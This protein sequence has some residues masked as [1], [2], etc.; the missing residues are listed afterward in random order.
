MTWEADH[1]YFEGRQGK[2]IR[3]ERYYGQLTLGWNALAE[4]ELL[5]ILQAFDPSAPARIVPS[6]VQPTLD[7]VPRGAAPEYM[8]ECTSKVPVA[9]AGD[10]PG[11]RH[12]L[13]LSFRTLSWLPER[14]EPGATQRSALEWLIAQERII[15]RSTGETPVTLDDP[16]K[17]DYRLSVTESSETVAGTVDVP[18][19][20]KLTELTPLRITDPLPPLPSGYE[21]I[22][23]GRL[24]DG[25][26]LDFSS[27]GYA[28]PLEVTSPLPVQE[29][30]DGRVEGSVLIDSADV[31]A[32]ESRELASPIVVDSYTTSENETKEKNVEPLFLPYGFEGTINGHAENLPT[33]SNGDV[34]TTRWVV[35]V[36][37]R[38]AYRGSQAYTDSYEYTSLNADGSFSITVSPDDYSSYPDKVGNGHPVIRLHDQ[39]LSGNPPR[40]DVPYDLFRTGETEDRNLSQYRIEGYNVTDTD[41]NSPSMYGP[42]FSNG[43]FLAWGHN[44]D[45]GRRQYQLVDRDTGDDVGGRWTNQNN[46]KE[47][48][49]FEVRL[50][51][52]S[53]QEY[54]QPDYTRPLYTD[55]TWATYLDGAV[56]NKGEW[57]VRLHRKSDGA[58]VVD[59]YKGDI[60]RYEELEVVGEL[61][62]GLKYQKPVQYLSKDESFSFDSVDTDRGPFVVKVRRQSDLELLGQGS[63]RGAVPR[64]FNY[65]P[66]DAPYGKRQEHRSFC[67]DASL[68][69]LVAT[70][71][72][73]PEQAKRLARGLL[74]MQN[75]GEYTYDEDDLPS[76]DSNSVGCFAWFTDHF[77]PKNWWDYYGQPVFRTA[78]D[79]WACYALAKYLS[80]FPDS[81]IAEEARDACYLVLDHWENFQ[82]PTGPP[83]YGGVKFGYNHYDGPPD[84]GYTEDYKPWLGW[85]AMNEVWWGCN[86]A[87]DVFADSRWKSLRDQIK[88]SLLQGFWVD[89]P[90]DTDDVPDGG[91]EV[92]GFALGV[93]EDTSSFPDEWGAQNRDRALD[94]WTWGGIW[95]EAVGEIERLRTM[96]KS[97]YHWAVVDESTRARGKRVSGYRPHS[98]WGG[99]EGALATL[100]YEGS[101]GAAL[102]FK[103]IGEEENYTRQLEELFKGQLETG[104]FLYAED[105]DEEYQIGDQPSAASTT[106]AVLATQLRHFL[107]SSGEVETPSAVVSPPP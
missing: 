63:G 64:S 35:R 20:F 83:F 25:T 47:L 98:P 21:G 8:C 76:G 62:V 107:W 3:Q 52:Y 39:S 22:V 103:R 11:G 84:Y 69:L 57:W 33:D 88:K 15:D 13:T 37:Y 67:Y 99:Y 79:G 81:E 68:A 102:Y 77:R 91:H 101:F 90:D 60:F 36:Y 82:Q 87:Y 71:R 12:S 40:P 14:P 80:V 100:W 30:Y 96:R 29:N 49:K 72:E 38:N 61:W 41:Y 26:G 73:E 2:Q 43:E 45:R 55:Q 5:D 23:R 105:Y 32:F 4:Q 53:D 54:A 86:A 74:R 56:T 65:A 93:H 6:T 10:V 42:V 17:A 28:T 59:P 70:G 7:L 34:D 85:E 48:T 104:G 94:Q 1:L 46:G 51:H 9:G 92:E 106:W 50:S 18:D 24:T 89:G 44:E 31:G 95:L 16:E 58:E 66:G 78:T 27:E 75:T 97:L 19:S